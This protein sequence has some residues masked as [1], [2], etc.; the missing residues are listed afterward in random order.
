M[1]LP[2]LDAWFTALAAVLPAFAKDPIS[3]HTAQKLAQGTF[4]EERATCPTAERGYL[5]K[6]ELPGCAQDL[7]R[8]E[9]GACG[10]AGV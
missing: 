3:Q 5:G 8:P 9:P 6:V 4:R 1:R 10:V 7:L 2:N